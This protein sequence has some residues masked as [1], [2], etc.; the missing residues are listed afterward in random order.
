MEDEGMEPIPTYRR[1]K[2]VAAVDRGLSVAEVAKR[3]EISETTVRNYL[4]LR[5]SGSLEPKPRSGGPKPSLNDDD[6]ERL[7]A[8]VGARPDATLAELNE[9]C[10]F[11][12]SEATICRELQ[13]LDRPRKRKVPRASEQSEERIQKQ[14]VEWVARTEEIHPEQFI[15]VDESGIST[16]MTKRYGRAPQGL[17]VFTDVPMRHYE[18]LSVLSGIRL[19][20]CDELPTLVYPGGTTTERMLEYIDG[21]LDAVLQPGDIV[22]ADNLAAHKAKRVA[23][24]LD[25]RGASI[26]HLP[27]YSP[28]LN[29]IERLWS[30]IKTSLRS[31]KAKTVDRLKAAL[32]AALNTITNQDIYDWFLHS[33]YLEPD[34]ATTN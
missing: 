22:V 25:E 20:G 17:P 12:V 5:E 7:L 24:A 31:A 18:S 27:S 14:R 15:F 29:P 19:G 11:D 6:R 1:K 8:A 9:T 2:I 10:Q 28:D 13:K 16:H 26:W 23:A 34:L 3:F 33:N 21:P 4:K 30:K 32:S